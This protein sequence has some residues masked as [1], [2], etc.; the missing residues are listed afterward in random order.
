MVRQASE[1]RAGEGAAGQDEEHTGNGAAERDEDRAGDGA[2]ERDEDRAAAP[3][4]LERARRVAVD[5]ARAAGWLITEGTRAALVVNPKG[6]DGDVV[7]DLDLS[8][9]RLLVGRVLSAFPG[10]AVISEEA[11][12][13]GEAGSE[14]TWVIDPLDG[15]NNVAIGLPLYAVGLALC[16]GGRPE[17]GVVHEPVTGRTWSAVRGRGAVG[18]AGPLSAPPYRPGRSG[19]VLAWVQGYGVRRGDPVATALK[20]ALDLRARRVL[21]LWAP[22]LAW[23]MLARGD[24]DGIVGYRTGVVDLPGGLLIAREAGAVVGGFDGAPFDRVPL[25]GSGCDFV[26]GRAGLREELLEEVLKEAGAVQEAAR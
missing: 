7:T 23:V 13:L 25:D 9:E 4:D 1:G 6:D 24:I 22:L 11:G 3:T 12:V 17:L 14:W 26:A 18:P 8:S 2:A 16:R 21:R 19:P 5:A 10:H 20:A 15:T